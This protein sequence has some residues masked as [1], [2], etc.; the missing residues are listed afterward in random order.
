MKRLTD[1]PQR[2]AR[3]YAQTI[4]LPF[5]WGTHDCAV[6]PLRAADAMCGTAHAEAMA[7]MYDDEYGAQGYCLFRGWTTLADA[8][9]EFGCRPLANA[10]TAQRGDIFLFAPGTRPNEHAG[11]VGVLGLQV[12][13]SVYVVTKQGL[14][15]WTIRTIARAGAVAYAVGR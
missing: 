1:W 15:R 10:L 5:A 2:L 9:A 14:A 8:L 4:H 3:F 13:G 6:W 7:G 12:D 11:A